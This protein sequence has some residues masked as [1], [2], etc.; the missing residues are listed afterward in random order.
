MSARRLR[1]FLA[2]AGVVLAACTNAITATPSPSE[3]PTGRFTPD[4]SATPTARPSSAESVDADADAYRTRWPIKHVVFVVKENRT[5]DNLFG[6]FPGA[7]GVSVGMDHGQPRPLKRG[8]DGRIPGDIPHCYFC[9]RAAWDDG[10]M[11]RFDQGITGDWAYT[12]LQKDQLPNYW[13]WAKHNVLFD[14][15]FSSAWARRG[16]RSRTDV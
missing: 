2:A 3:S 15:F 8:T 16:G 11:D 10:A 1:P 12:Q 6:T 9:S 7:N 14:K 5:F 13:H 4:I